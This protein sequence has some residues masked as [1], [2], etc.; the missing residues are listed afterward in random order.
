LVLGVRATTAL[1]NVCDRLWE[2]K[3]EVVSLTRQRD[4]LQEEVFILKDENSGLK[5]RLKRVRKMR[6]AIAER[7]IFYTD[8]VNTRLLE[9]EDEMEEVQE[10]GNQLQRAFH[11][12]SHIPLPNGHRKSKSF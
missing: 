10:Q 3:L 8:F 1:S 2:R 12:N 9:F 6:R 11:Q 7:L 5:K 4:E